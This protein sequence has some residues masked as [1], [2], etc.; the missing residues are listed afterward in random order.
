[1]RKAW[2]LLALL[3]LLTGCGLL[4]KLRVKKVGDRLQETGNKFRSIVKELESNPSVALQRQWVTETVGRL[5]E[6]RTE[7]AEIQSQ[8]EGIRAPGRY[9]EA[10]DKLKRGVQLLVEATDLL[11]DALNLKSIPKGRQAI[12]KASEAERLLRE[13]ADE[14]RG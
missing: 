8:L 10:H 7:L 4:Y 6:I 14:I 3:P 13:A 9:R 1:M 2:L 11:I 12:Q 5:Q